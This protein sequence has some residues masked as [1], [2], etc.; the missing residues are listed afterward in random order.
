M[1]VYLGVYLT[2]SVLDFLKVI[3]PSL[4]LCFVHE[5]CLPGLLG[6]P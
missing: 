1:G 4:L 2:H 6:F 5:C 3:D